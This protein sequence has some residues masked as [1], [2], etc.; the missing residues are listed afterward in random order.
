MCADRC[1]KLCQLI[2]HTVHV[3]VVPGPGWRRAA[4]LDMTDPT[5]TC[6]PTWELISIPRRSCGRSSDAVGRTYDSAVFPTLNNRYTQVFGRIKG[7][8]VGQ[9]GVFYLEN[10]GNPKT[11]D[12]PY[13]D[14]VSLTYQKS[15]TTHLDIYR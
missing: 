11:I 10:T 3:V 13:V 5:Q 6:P 12:G 2:L 8:Q 7:C 4:Y 14:G 1:L 15:T 9:T